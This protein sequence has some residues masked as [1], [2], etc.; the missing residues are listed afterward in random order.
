MVLVVREELWHSFS[1]EWEPIGNRLVSAI[2]AKGNEEAWIVGVYAPTNASD[3]AVNGEFYDQLHNTL[4][5]VPDT[6][7]LVLLGDFNANI[8]PREECSSSQ[9]VG[10]NG[11]S[12][13]PTS[14][15]GLCL[16]ELCSC[17][18]LVLTN[19][20]HKVRTRDIMTYKD[21]CSSSE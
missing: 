17:Y 1:G 4:R 8:N 21:K 2:F 14:D 3:V 18:S 9:V 10:P 11:C 12:W 15:N 6:A 13:R 7:M 19:T 16:L 5:K 20:L